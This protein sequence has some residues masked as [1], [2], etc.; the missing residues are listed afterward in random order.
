MIRAA[1]DA[2]L[3]CYTKIPNY[4]ARSTKAGNA[5]VLALAAI[6]GVEAIAQLQRILQRVKLPSQRAQVEKALD[7]AATAQRAE[8]GRPR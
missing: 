7:A 2:A 5:A 1:G 4:G 6:P 8:P 3:A